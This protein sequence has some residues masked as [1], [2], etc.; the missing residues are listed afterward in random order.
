MYAT[1]TNLQCQRGQRV[2][3]RD[4][5]SP[6]KFVGESF[7]NV[8]ASTTVAQMFLF[9]IILSLTKPAFAYIYIYI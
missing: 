3:P 4:L 1:K 6:L 9:P 7:V 5:N 8:T 2:V